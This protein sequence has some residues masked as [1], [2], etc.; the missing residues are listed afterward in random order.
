MNG[1]MRIHVSTGSPQNHAAVEW[2]EDDSC[3]STIILTRG[4]QIQTNSESLRNL[5]E[6]LD[7][8]YGNPAKQR[9]IRS[10]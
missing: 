5:Y 7:V 10:S 1:N 3:V 4:G 2:M 6:C 9:K 8:L